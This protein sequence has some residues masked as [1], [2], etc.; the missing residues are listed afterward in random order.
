MHEGLVKQVRFSSVDADA[1][2]EHGLVRVRPARRSNR[3]MVAKRFIQ[4]AFLVGSLP[5]LL[6]Y[7]TSRLLFGPRALLSASESIARIPG[8]RGV[9]LRQAFYR[10]TLAGCGRDVYLGWQSV[11]SMRE[12][13][14]GERAYIGRFCSIGFA[15]IGEEAMLADGVQIL[16]GGH[17]HSTDRTDNETI[18][19]QCQR[20][21]KVRIGRGAWIG[22]RAIIMAD[23]GPDAIVGA[24]AV[25]NRP[26]P[27]G[28]VAVGVPA[29]VV[30]SPE[31]INS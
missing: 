19:E 1:N 7:Q 9:Y 17:E 12:A 22:A 3:F 23:V 26:I 5:R 27:A 6:V 8:M 29:R 2:D 25:V 10:R 14:V 20:Y 24:G 16:S 30:K 28:C 11:F 18:H 4:A 31:N 13:K 15:D 21:Q